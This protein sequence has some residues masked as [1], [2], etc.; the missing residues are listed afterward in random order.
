MAIVRKHGRPDLFVTFTANPTWREVRAEA[1]GD[2][3]DRPDVL[4]RVFRLK[5]KRLLL[6]V[7]SGIFGEIKGR[8]YTIEYQKR[9]LPHAHMLI[10]LQHKLYTSSDIDAVICAELPRHNERLCSIVSRNLTHTCSPARCMRDGTCAK[11]FP[12]PMSPYTI[13][14]DKGKPFQPY[15]HLKPARP[16]NPYALTNTCPR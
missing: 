7:D 5:L 9:G 10:W 12:K 4:A 14:D 15:D 6:E 1:R 3:A 13:V 16:I 8:V 11:R 2:P